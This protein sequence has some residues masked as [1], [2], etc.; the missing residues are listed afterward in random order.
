MSRRPALGV[1]P[2]MVAAAIAIATVD[3]GVEANGVTDFRVADDAISLALGGLAGDHERGQKVVSDR[4]V[5]NCLICHAIPDPSQTFQGD[6]GPPLH[7]VGSRL[8]EGQ[9]RLR[10]VDQSRLNSETIMP[11][12]HRV[13]GLTN[14]AT[15]FRGRPVLSAQEVEDVVAYLASLRD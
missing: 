12:Y 11:P 2:L 1:R 14:V 4:E 10:I 9:L 15:A 6:L 7:G 5:G 13:D 8:S 3:F